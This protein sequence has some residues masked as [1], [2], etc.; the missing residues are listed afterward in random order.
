VYDNPPNKTKKGKEIKRKKD[1][2]PSNAW[3]APR[4][5]EKQSIDPWGF[6]DNVFFDN[7]DFP[8]LDPPPLETFTFQDRA[9]RNHAGTMVRLTF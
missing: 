3:L 9:A 2:V 4:L 1:G 8:V 5:G 6:L 7:P